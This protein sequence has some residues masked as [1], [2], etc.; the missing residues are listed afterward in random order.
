MIPEIKGIKI[1]IDVYEGPK[2]YVNEI[3]WDGNEI[4]SDADLNK[5]LGIVLVIYL[6]K[7][8]LILP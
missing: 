5:E 4:I 8:N 2:Y 7:K 1:V 6:I 3:N